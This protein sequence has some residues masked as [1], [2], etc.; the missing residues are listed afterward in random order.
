MIWQGRSRRK[1]SGGFYRKARKKRK[2]ELGRE[3]VETLTGE[4]KVK[5]IRV[6]GGNY[7]LKLFA[8][9]YA[10]VY[11]PKQGKVIR[12]EIESVVENP[13]HVHYA[14]R[15][16]ITKGAIISTS[17]GKAKVTNRPSQEG[18]VNAVLIE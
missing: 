8:E 3:Q 5:K 13:A 14:R 4:R 18:V 17:I 16:V 15:N 1:P 7:K 10:N 6:R 11:D 9:K 2:Y 12:A